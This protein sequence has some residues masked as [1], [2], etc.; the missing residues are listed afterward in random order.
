MISFLKNVNI[1]NYNINL[2]S[3]KYNMGIGFWGKLKDFGKRAGHWLKTKAI[4]FL[5]NTVVPIAKVVA[6][7][8]AT[9][10][11]GAEAGKTAGNIVN[12]ADGAITTADN[13]LN[14]GKIDWGD[15]NKIPLFRK[16]AGGGGGGEKHGLGVVPISKEDQESLMKM[17]NKRNG[18]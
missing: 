12:I 15:V 2:F 4:P 13:F 6:P 3:F 11:G 8:V 1:N 18:R 10:F 14:K 9:Y 17:I 16:S 7:A 5:K